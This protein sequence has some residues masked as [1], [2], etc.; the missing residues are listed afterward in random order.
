[1]SAHFAD[2]EWTEHQDPDCVCGH[3]PHEGEA[4]PEEIRIGGP[5][6]RGLLAP[7]GC[8]DYVP[9]RFD[10]TVGGNQ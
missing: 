10:N 6:A 1:M 8:D 2:G 3:L 5:L 9:S 4:C 7:C